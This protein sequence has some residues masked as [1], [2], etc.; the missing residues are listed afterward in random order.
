MVAWANFLAAGNN[1]SNP[2]AGAEKYLDAFETLRDLAAHAQGNTLD[3]L[4]YLEDGL[5]ELAAYKQ[6]VIELREYI[7]AWVPAVMTLLRSAAASTA[8]KEED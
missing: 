3:R 7:A 4:E 8:T 6:E 2:P 5:I 1:P